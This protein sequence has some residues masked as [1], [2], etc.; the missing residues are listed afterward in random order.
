MAAA[1]GTDEGAAWVVVAARSG[2][3]LE[4]RAGRNA[5][6]RLRPS[7]SGIGERASPH[8]RVLYR[9]LARVGLP[10]AWGW[11]GAG[12]ALGVVR[13]LFQHHRPRSGWHMD[14]AV[15]VRTH[16]NTGRRPVVHQLHSAPADGTAGYGLTQFRVAVGHRALRSKNEAAPRPRSSALSSVKWPTARDR[17][18]R[19]NKETG[20][21]PLTARGALERAAKRAGRS[22]GRGCWSA[23]RPR[24]WR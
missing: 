13:A 3:G 1:S 4:C 11:L 12:S 6:W 17:R 14:G 24:R 8:E 20:R 16:A 10:G 23:T 15:A 19:S 5:R 21:V 22:R 18:T 2:R 9:P 7:Q